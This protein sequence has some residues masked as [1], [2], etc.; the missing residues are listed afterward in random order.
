MISIVCWLW[1]DN[2]TRV[3]SPDHVNI[4]WRMLKRN[5]SI[6]FHFICITDELS[7][8]FDVGI[9]IVR[10]PAAALEAGKLRSPEGVRFPSCYRRLWSF[11]EEAKILGE[12]CLFIDIDCVIMNDLAPLFEW[13]QDFMGWRPYRDWGNR[14]RFGGGTYLLTTGT[15]TNV[16]TAFNGQP[17]IAKARGAGYRGSDQAWL[18]YCL[19]EK[20]PYWPREAGIYSV[21][22]LKH[23][24]IAPSDARLIHL[25]GPAKPWH[26]THQWVKENW[27]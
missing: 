4:L 13:K 15:R 16:W 26:S 24:G 19:A 3:F 14:L 22:D 27:K 18:S 9:S 20:E 25:N 12:R 5:M 1:K 11:S 10:T 8:L 21:R 6:E 2:D 23:Q 17:A 7:E